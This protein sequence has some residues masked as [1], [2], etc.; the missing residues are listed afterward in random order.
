MS[1]IGKIAVIYIEIGLAIALLEPLLW[2]VLKPIALDDLY[3][4]LNHPNRAYRQGAMTGMLLGAILIWPIHLVTW[5]IV[6]PI[7][8]W[9]KKRKES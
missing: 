6:D 3:E 9:H 2:K 4:H 7:V 5:Y 1:T 8:A